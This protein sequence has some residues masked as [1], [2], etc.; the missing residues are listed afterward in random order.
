MVFYGVKSNEDFPASVIHGKGSKVQERE[1]MLKG[2]GGPRKGPSGCTR[3]RAQFQIPRTQAKARESRKLPVKQGFPGRAGV[4]QC[5]LE[6][7][8]MN[9]VENGR[10]RHGKK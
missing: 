1:E 2:W 10:G 9:E 6:P 4:Q 3:M 7:A 5:S 8:S